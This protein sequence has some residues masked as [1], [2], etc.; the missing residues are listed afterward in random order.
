M[1]TIT[2]N[3]S[4]SLVL[5]FPDRRTRKPSGRDESV[6]AILMEVA[7]MFRAARRPQHPPQRTA[8]ILQHP[9]PAKG[10]ALRRARDCRDR[11]IM[12]QG[13]WRIGA[14]GAA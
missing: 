8:Q 13:Q 1:G 10:W 7:A 9:R 2:S 14:G 6:V 3:P 12:A 4:G 5:P 11:A